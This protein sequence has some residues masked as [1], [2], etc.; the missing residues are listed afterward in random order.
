M[1]GKSD[2]YEAVSLMAST[3][4]ENRDYLNE[5]DGAIGD[6]DFGTSISGGFRAVQ[7]IL[8]QLA[9]M[10]PGQ[11]LSKVGMTLVSKVG[12]ASGPIYGTIFMKAGQ[13]AGI[14]KELT[15]A[16]VAVML[17][18]AIMGVK[19]R[20]KAEL[21]EKTIVDALQPAAEAFRQAADDGHPLAECGARAAA[22]A[23]SGAE[24][25]KTL[26]ATKGRAHYV[27]ERGLGHPDAGA[28]SIALLFE[29]ICSKT[30]G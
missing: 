18:A 4:L 26:I 28:V 20:G 21:G 14:K 13:A 12:G 22:A 23:R 2:V 3:I 9:E 24:H 1:L 17:E 8:P 7:E 29:T 27:G 16:D 10:E 11:M 25:T 19:A 5:L 6:A 30:K 15:V